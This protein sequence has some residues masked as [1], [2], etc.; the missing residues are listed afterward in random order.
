MTWSKFSCGKLFFLTEGKHSVLR[1]VLASSYHLATISAENPLELEDFGTASR[2]GVLWV[3]VMILRLIGVQRQLNWFWEWTLQR[4]VSLSLVLKWIRNVY[5]CSSA[6]AKIIPY[7]SSHLVK[8]QHLSIKKI[9]S[10]PRYLPGVLLYSP[11]RATVHTAKW[12]RE[13]YFLILC[14][15]SR[16]NSNASANIHV[17]WGNNLTQSQ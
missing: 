15:Q 8:Q 6:W 11:Q 5:V 3:R 14:V 1:P 10:T 4:T 13:I 2:E 16:C 7:I 12:N 9:I 17:T